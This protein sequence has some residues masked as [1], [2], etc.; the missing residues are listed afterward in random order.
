MKSTIVCFVALMCLSLVVTQVGAQET[1]PNIVGLLSMEPITD[2][3]CAAIWLPIPEGKAVTGVRWFNNDGMIAFPQILL[4]SGEEELVVDLS[5]TVEVATNVTGPAEAWGEFMFD[6][7]YA[8]QSEGLY[9][10]FMMA[11]DA[12]FG[13]P[14]VGA[15]FGFT[16]ANHGQRGWLGGEED[17]W[18]RIGGNYSLAIEPIIVD[19]EEGMQ[20]MKSMPGNGVAVLATP[21]LAGAYPNPFNPQTVLEYSVPQEMGVKLSIYDVRGKLVRHL[22]SG[23]QSTGIHRVTWMGDDSDGRRMASGVY[24]AQFRAGAVNQSQRLLLVK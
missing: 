17:T 3:S 13:G 2:E 12:D 10:V 15:A 22:V 9:C 7:P 1:P 23:Q 6:Q 21:Q 8:C 5:E 11:G 18:T 24:L 19:A 16:E 20:E 14:G 4:A